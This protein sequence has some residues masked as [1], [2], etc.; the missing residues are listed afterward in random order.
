MSTT[1]ERPYVRAV[2]GT[3]G[4]IDHG[5]SSLIFS[6]TG[7]HPSRLKEEQERGMTIDIGYA[8]LD[9]GGG[10][11]AGIIDVPGHE[12]FIRNMVAGSSGVDYAMLVVAADDGVMPQ[13]REHLQIMRLLGI[14]IGVTVLTKVDAV[15][16]ELLEIVEDDVRE[17]LVGTFLEKAPL[18]RVSNQTGEG[19]DA[20]REHLCQAIPALPDRDPSGVFRMPV[21]RSFSVKG[22]GT[23]VTGVPVSGSVR[24]GEELELLPRGER[25]RVRGMQ[26]HHQPAEEAQIGHR[27]ALN[28]SDV[29]WRD[30]ERGD[31]LAE[32]GYFG[33][34]SLLEAR[35]EYLDHLPRPLENETPVR[36][37]AGTTDVG[38][39]IVLLDRKVMLP[40]DRGLVQLRLDEPVVIAARDRFIV[41]LASPVITLGGGVVVG[42][43]KWRFKRFR[44]WLNENLE[45]KERHMDD[46]EGYL[47]YVVR[48]QGRKLTARS[49][50]C[51]AVKKTADEIEALV[52]RLHEKGVVRVL[53]KDRRVIH[54][55]MY[56]EAE[57]L[58]SKTLLAAHKAERLQA[59]FHSARIARDARL[60]VDLVEAVLAELAEGKK[61]EI[62][63]RGLV[64]HR[65]WS[66]GLSK[67]DMGLVERIE[68]MH[69]REH[70]GAP[71][72]SEIVTA[73][74]RPQKKVKEL[75]GFL[76]QM[77]KLI[78]LTPDL[79]L[80]R[81]AVVEAQ[82]RLVRRIREGGPMPS[83]EF[84]DI[85]GATRKYVIPLLEYFDKQQITRRDGNERKLADGWEKRVDPEILEADGDA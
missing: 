13:T 19:I 84:K 18:F 3:A 51:R 80:H 30:V 82:R 27:A 53:G 22:H 28:L 37:H 23:V 17:Y 38:G 83:S 39:R 14:E 76:H 75:M 45:A 79:S 4:H 42:E 68:E 24:V 70:F 29:S 32:P 72:F 7:T 73:L 58:V 48:S 20:L 35:F 1:T 41:R 26:V 54:A 11:A 40:G 65:E 56:S 15:D 2:I 62:L 81:D 12:R 67:E 52:G 8:E 59:G 10:I 55:D 50:L 47:A 36:F 9:L 44:A 64:R 63:G 77:G 46:E 69:S 57:A 16:A 5:K 21:Q 43:T 85:I 49:E 71:I 25:V 66:G 31:V 34:A 74:D 78:H 61:V 33:S 60:G 6:L